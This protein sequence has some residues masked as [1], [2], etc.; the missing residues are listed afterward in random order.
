MFKYRKFKS[1]VFFNTFHLLECWKFAERQQSTLHRCQHFRIFKNVNILNIFQ[2]VF[3]IWKFYC[4]FFYFTL[5][6]QIFL[7]FCNSLLECKVK[8]FTIRHW[9]IYQFVQNNIRNIKNSCILWPTEV[10][11]DCEILSE[12]LIDIP[13]L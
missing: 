8:N 2:T 12:A 5:H 9:K 13:Q 11:L 6:E 3:E 7:E 10:Q 4:N 1:S